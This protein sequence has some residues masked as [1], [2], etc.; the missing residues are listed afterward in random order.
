MSNKTLLP[1]HHVILFF[2]NRASCL[3][4]FCP[5]YM[6][7][8]FLEGCLCFILL[9]LSHLCLLPKYNCLETGKCSSPQ[10]KIKKQENLQIR[11]GKITGNSSTTVVPA[12]GDPV[13]TEIVRSMATKVDG[14][15]R[16][17][18]LSCVP[19]KRPD[20]SNPKYTV[21]PSLRHGKN[22]DS[23]FSKS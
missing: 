11:R 16:C 14:W 19:E 20:V 4:L 6:Q 22:A 12:S 21:H 15:H 10:K 2:Y 5:R 8:R 9:G 23:C 18:V 3:G 7:P 1:G 13:S 17:V